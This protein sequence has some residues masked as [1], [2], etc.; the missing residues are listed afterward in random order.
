M[1]SLRPFLG[2]RLVGGLQLDVNGITA[3]LQP[4]ITDEDVDKI[5]SRCLNPS[6]PVEMKRLLPKGVDGSTRRY[7]SFKI[8][9]DPMYKDAALN[10]MTW[11]TGLLFREFVDQPKNYNR[12]PLTPAPMVQR[13][14]P[15]EATTPTV[16]GP[17][18][19]TT[20]PAALIDGRS[21]LTPKSS[22]SISFLYQNVGGVNSCVVDYLLA[23][24]CSSYDII[25]FTET[26]LNDRTL[27]SQIISQ[28][29]AVFR[30]DR[31]SLNSR[32]STGGGV[33]LAVKA[34]LPSMLIEDNSWE[35][36]EL[37]WARID[38]GDRKLYLCVVYVPPDRS[39][40][41]VLAESFSRCLTKVSSM[42]SPE[43]D[44]LVI[45]D[46][47][48]P[49]LKWCSSRSGF[50]FP[51]PVRSSFS[52]SSNIFLDTLSTATLRQINNI[53]NENGRLLDL[54]FVNEG[55]RNPTIDLAPAPLV[56]PVP[57]H[58]A[59]VISLDV[60]VIFAPAEK[61]RSY[62]HDFKNADY[63]A[64]SL[65]LDSTNWADELDF[66]DPNAAAEKFSNILSYTIDRHV[67]KR[68]IDGD[69]RTPWVTKELRRQKTA[70]K[71]ALRNYHK[72]KCLI[73]KREYRKLNSAYKKASKRCYLTYLNRLQRNFKSRPKSFWKYVKNQRKESGLPSH[74]Y[75][76]DDIA[77]TDSGIC[78]LFAEKFSNIFTSGSISAEQLTRAVSNVSPLGSSLAGPSLQNN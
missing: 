16:S 4:Q 42:C 36:L 9:L 22:D 34:E 68:S 8:G 46:F 48:L 55:F 13:F 59:L 21:R 58:P 1:I 75:L 27:S 53:E 35:D 50:L 66:S 6:T 60:A 37:L 49:G 51:D 38:L 74:M 2:G 11:P 65:V 12:Q 39:G 33:L 5:I 47:N 52:A 56:K 31:S 17:G 54:C 30:C 43:D 18:R 20:A 14:Q 57:H 24:S 25:A 41:Q 76:D 64:I 70:K 32:K 78:N 45:C 61:T 62:Y 69:L 28:D 15:M 7:V 77:S 72:H 63:V 29:Y 40:D 23:T 10:P 71:C 73:T 67:P 26:W 44:I 19:S 3:G